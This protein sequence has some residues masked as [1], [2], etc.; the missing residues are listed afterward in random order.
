[1]PIITALEIQK[2][3]KE[4]V[5]VYLDGEF[6]FGLTLI[7][8]A[9]LRKG[10]E[11]T[12]AQIASLRAD[13]EVNRAYNHAVRFLGY[14]PR[15]IA[16]VQKN[17]REKGYSDEAIQ[18]TLAKLNDQHYLDDAAFA[19]YW[20]ANRIEFKPR[21]ARALRTELRQKGVA[22]AI[23]T[24]IL[25]EHDAH[26]DAYRAAQQK[27]RRYKNTTKAEFKQ[28][29]GQFLMRRGF[30]YHTIQPVLVQ[31]IEELVTDDPHFFRNGG[32]DTSSDD[33]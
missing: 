12:D 18:A 13:D 27:V 1:M 26:D 16:E 23:I 28:K 32:D 8:A 24:E 29:V 2:R 7:E 3:D 33:F 5:N 15:S 11:L 31:L 20:V 6:A 19:R 9:Q 21:G 25:A 30:D 10:Q 4:R 17:L 22:D 14:R